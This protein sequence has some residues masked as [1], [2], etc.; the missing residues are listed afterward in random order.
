MDILKSKPTKIDEYSYII[1]IKAIYNHLKEYPKTYKIDPIMFTYFKNKA[2]IFC[3]SDYNTNSFSLPIGNLYIG[4]VTSIC[5][6]GNIFS[7]SVLKCLF[8]PHL[9]KSFEVI[10]SEIGSLLIH[11][12]TFEEGDFKKKYYQSKIKKQ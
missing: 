9:Q 2:S 10:I 1:I 5:S 12:N 4:P 8:F 11:Q 6:H 3:S 7:S